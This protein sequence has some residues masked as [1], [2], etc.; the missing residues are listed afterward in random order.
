[1]RRAPIIHRKL[2]LAVLAAD[3]AETVLNANGGGARG[4][5]QYIYHVDMTARERPIN[6]GR[7]QD[8]QL[9]GSIHVT[10]PFPVGNHYSVVAH[11]LRRRCG[12]QMRELPV[13]IS[14]FVE[15]HESPDRRQLT[16]RLV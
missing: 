9:P 12:L 11:E 6:P 13:S 10:S 3:M 16:L 1:M 15:R 2:R 4:N 8:V 7:L 14:D 5:M